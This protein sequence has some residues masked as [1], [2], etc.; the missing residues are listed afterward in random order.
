M[1]KNK[2]GNWRIFLIGAIMF[3]LLTNG[4][5]A[6]KPQVY[7]VGILYA[8]ES[9]LTIGESFMTHMTDLGY[10]EGE[11]IIYDIRQEPDQDKLQRIAEE[12][13]DNKVD[14]IFAFPDGAAIA[15]KAATA[16]TDI[17]VIF[18]SSFTELNDL[19]KSVNAPGGNMTGV[20]VPGPEITLLI[21]KFLLELQP[22]T[23]RIW[24]A[25]DPEYAPNQIAF[26]VW[27]PAAS[28]LGV[29][30]VEVPVKSA[31][32]VLADLQEREAADDIGVD[33][34]MIM[35]DVIVRSPEA[36]DAILAFGKAHKIPV[37]GGSSRTMSQGSLLT[38]TTDHAEQ[39]E[40]AAAIADQIFKGA[41]PG[42]IPVRTPD[43]LFILNY[44]AAQE[45]GI[46]V[47]DDLLRKA[48]EVLR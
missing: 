13:V 45:L 11:N 36:F 34:M 38:V 43:T 3:S 18:A 21:Q 12:F 22:N 15:A 20:R 39:G 28:S 35:P 10:V 41:D 4:C 14:L 42:T 6:K 17:P 37:V 2:A 9:Q 7:H 33:A 31:E 32:D 48:D 19:V 16:G 5:G 23:H 25:Y 29:T 46:T 27:R 24:A 1:V 47:S 44:K 26:E 30:V 8:V 40:H